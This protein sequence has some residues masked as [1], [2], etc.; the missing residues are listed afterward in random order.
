[1]SDRP[2]FFLV[3]DNP[4]QLSL[5]DRK[6]KQLMPECRTITFS[7]AR[8]AIATLDSLSPAAIFSDVEMPHMD[9]FTFADAIKHRKVPI[10]FVS[11]HD[12]YA[13]KAIRLSAID[14]LLKPVSTEELVPV[15]DKLMTA[16]ANNI[17]VQQ[18]LPAIRNSLSQGR[19][20]K[21]MINTA[22]KVFVVPMEQLIYIEAS[23]AYTIFH[24]IKEVQITSSYSIAYYENL[25]K[26]S[27]LFRTHRSF[28]VNV[29]FIKEIV[30]EGDIITIDNKVLPVSRSLIKPLVEFMQAH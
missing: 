7:D 17:M 18:E 20:E 14:Y 9:G 21:V 28:M 12:H 4:D 3:D 16:P 26:D 5:L 2:L 1:M 19:I 15:L 8:D 23:R 10:V 24:L 30:K 6:I 22:D 29:R 11:A 27:Q 25:L 13:I